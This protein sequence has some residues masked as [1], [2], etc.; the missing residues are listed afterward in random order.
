MI[1]HVSA[2]TDA[3]LAAGVPIT[4]VNS[5]GI[6][7]PANL[8]AAAQPTINAFDDS[9]A[10][11]LVRDNLAA[12]VSASSLLD[13][14]KSATLK[15][16]RAEAGLTIDELNALRQWVMSFKAAVA[17]ATTLAD[18]KARVATLADLPDRTQAQA[19]TAI[20]AKINAGSVD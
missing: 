5:N 17:A 14:N 3:I 16:L 2:L 8:Q 18:L 9:D 1:V 13:I 7:S 6:V 11:Q 12:R 19:I 10:A 4:G 20:K 15:L